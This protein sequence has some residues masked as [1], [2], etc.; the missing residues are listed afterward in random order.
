[1]SG[2]SDEGDGRR[3]EPARRASGPRSRCPRLERPSPGHAPGIAAQPRRPRRPPPAQ[4][5]Q[6]PPRDPGGGARRP[7]RPARPRRWG[8]RLGVV[9]LVLVVLLVGLGVWVDSR[10]N[11]IEAL[12]D[13]QGR[14]AATP[15]PTG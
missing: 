10:L 14:P 12:S 13:Y 2:W 4:P 1:M 5:R 3:A 8:R 15:G 6:R 9:L 7:P 11:R